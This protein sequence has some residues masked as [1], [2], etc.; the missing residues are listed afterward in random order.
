MT[1]LFIVDT[2]T[3]GISDTDQLCEI[4]GTLYQIGQSKKETGAI[5]SI[6]TL[7]PLTIDNKA[8]AINGIPKELTQSIRRYS[9]SYGTHRLSVDLFKKMANS[10]D[11][12]VAFC[13]NFD[14][15]LIDSL[16]GK[17]NWICAMQDF[18]WGYPIKNAY[19]GYKLIDLALWLGIGISTCHRAGDDVRLLVECLN[20]Y[21]DSQDI[22]L[23]VDQAIVRANSP[24]LEI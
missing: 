17:Q 8:E 22:K 3:T 7:M 1:T 2:E 12:C 4:A 13:V 19:G 16:I 14:A 23:L 15:P 6:S 11:Y 5:A 10:S 9:E 18:L 24:I 20:R 21:R